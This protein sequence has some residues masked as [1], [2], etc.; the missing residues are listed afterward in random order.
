M[1]TPISDPNKFHPLNEAGI[2][3]LTLQGCRCD[4][5]ERISICDGTE[6]D[7]IHNVRFSGDIKIGAGVVLENIGCLH[8]SPD[9]SFGV[10][11][12]VCVLDET[13]SRKVHIFPGIS[14]QTALLMARCPEWAE[15]TAK[16]AI[17]KAIASLPLTN[18]ISNGASI[19]NCKYIINV[20]IGKNVKIEGA[21]RLENGAVINNSNTGIGLCR[22]GCGVDAENFIVED[23]ILD[24][25]AIIRNCYVGQG[26]VIEKGFTAHDSLFFANSSM[27]NGEAVSLFS[28]PY[29]VSMHKSTLLIACQT[30][31]MN[32][33]SGT[34]QSNHMYKMGPIHW[35]IME[36]GVKTSSDSYLMLGAKIGA[37]SLLMGQHK[38]H[39]DSSEFPFSYLF[40]DDRGSTVVVPGAMLRSCGLLR[41][42]K[43][44][45]ARDRRL[46]AD[47]PPHDRIIYDVLN[48]LTV[49][50]M[51]K[52]LDTIHYLL[53]IPADDDRYLRYKG[54][55]FT[56]AA[57]ERA[58]TLYKLAIYKYLSLHP[59]PGKP[60]ETS[61]I[62]ESAEWI[63][64]AGQL[65]TKEELVNAM[66]QET[67]GDIETILNKSY[68]TYEKSQLKWIEAQFSNQWLESKDLINHYAAEFDAMVEEDR[69]KYLSELA[70]QNKMLQ[71][72]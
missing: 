14:A 32:A 42:E 66:A 19:R 5:W 69:Q 16:S 50:T 4:D 13:G 64:L 52:A 68:H 49:G 29:T 60:T 47:I 17:E 3:Q 25:G 44:W 27:E 56:R 46:N 70:S 20:H 36:R 9:A 33:G 53:T 40:G 51:L 39:P 18:E 54:M 30:S 34:N 48:P 26:C 6:L 41:D 24:S 71:L 37:F 8:L 58:L 2:R 22:I 35:G 65:I 11:T 28:G 55:K 15:T 43:K 45:P 67:I 12:N 1:T 23:G 10:G 21:D 38:T 59:L 61:P 31:F 62:S 57:L 63:D 72:I 7:K